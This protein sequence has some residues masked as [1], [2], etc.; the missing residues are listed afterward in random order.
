ML[1]LLPWGSISR[2][3]KSLKDDGSTPV[4]DTDH[5]PLQ[6]HLHAGL[7][8]QALCLQIWFCVFF[9]LFFLKCMVPDHNTKLRWSLPKSLFLESSS[10]Y[11]LHIFF[12]QVVWKQHTYLTVSTFFSCKWKHDV[13]WKH[14]IKLYES[15]PKLSFICLQKTRTNTSSLLLNTTKHAIKQNVLLKNNSGISGKP[16]R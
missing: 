8:L 4:F 14:I 7:E 2:H 9:V 11:S 10:K 6:W 12:K 1:T 16:F 13:M 5:Q 3:Q 15:W